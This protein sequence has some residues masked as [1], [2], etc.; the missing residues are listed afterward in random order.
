VT[1]SLCWIE[2][3][4]VGTPPR[5]SMLSISNEDTFV[6]NPNLDEINLFKQDAM[7]IAQRQYI[8]RTYTVIGPT[9]T[10]EYYNP[11]NVDITLNIAAYLTT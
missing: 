9:L 6:F 1:A 7:V 4:V 11:N 2:F 5:N 10:I 3:E 8:T